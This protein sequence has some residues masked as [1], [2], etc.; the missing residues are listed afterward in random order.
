MPVTPPEVELRDVQGLLLRGFG[1]LEHA[2]YL[3]LRFPDRSQPLR[4]LAELRRGLTSAEHEPPP[5]A[6]NVAFS[7]RGLE[8]LGL[9]ARAARRLDP[10]FVEGMTG[11][12]DDGS[13]HRSRLLGDRGESAPARWDWGNGANPVDAILLVFERE[14]PAVEALARQAT[15][16]AARCGLEIAA[17]LE[18]GTL[19]GRKEHFGFR[20]GISQPALRNAN[21][22]GARPGVLG[23]DREENGVEVGDFLLGHRD[24]YGQRSEGASL[25]ADVAGASILRPLG[26]GG[27]PHFGHDGSYLVVRQLE[28]D[29]AGFWTAVR[30]AADEAGADPIWLASRI[31]GRWPSGAPTVVARKSDAPE[32]SDHN[33]FG[34]AGSDPHG[35]ACP[36]GSHIRRANPRDWLL[37]PRPADASRLASL[38]RLIRRG[39]PYGD[40]LV[41][42]LAPEKLLVASRDDGRRGLQFLCFNASLERQ[43]EFVQ[44][45]W[46]EQRKFGGLR[47]E[48]DPVA[49]SDPESGMRF[50]VPGLGRPVQLR[51]L[52]RFVRVRGGAYFFLP[53]LAA[54]DWLLQTAPDRATPSY[55][56]A[57]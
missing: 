51:G 10:A 19:P 52:A 14:R 2:R 49:G 5:G 45:S 23:P 40:P 21:L 6:R 31:V 33:A 9:P 36:P 17:T 3:L 34:F 27:P 43:F 39:R 41:P 46:L 44:S 7:R 54:V 29:V 56:A 38:H 55:V 28:Q 8:R 42:D 20:D 57:T 16:H 32:W 53:G 47:D 11:G 48:T 35:F 30:D 25:P 1:R 22:P 37:A 15:E 26:D 24:G 12:V 4:W 50:H 18:A 13:S